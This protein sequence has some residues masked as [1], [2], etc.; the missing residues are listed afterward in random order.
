MRPEQVSAVIVTRGDVDLKPVLKSLVFDDVV[1]FN[2][3][4]ESADQMT[5]GR[6]LALKRCKH[7]VIYSQDDDIVHTPKNQRKIV[8]A[9]EP[10]RLTGCMWKEWSDGA[11]KQ[12]I[13]NG[14]DDLVF[15]GSGSVYDADTIWAAIDAYLDVYPFDDFFR[16]W[17][18]TIVGVLAPTKQLPIVFEALP[19]AEAGNRMC[20][21]P[22]AAALKTE[23][24]MRARSVR[25]AV[26]VH[27]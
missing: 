18:D 4:R 27:G 17:C 3:A 20:N 8:D 9:Y 5:F 14:Y 6:V 22:D 16:L 10:G 15:C 2:N 23:A 19:H 13:R 7:K 11:K 1:V 21:L 24:I 12:G 25:E 26:L